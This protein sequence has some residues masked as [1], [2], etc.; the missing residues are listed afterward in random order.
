MTWK[1]TLTASCKASFS[2]VPRLYDTAMSRAVQPILQY[3]FA[4]HEVCNLFYAELL[5]MLP[6]FGSLFLGTYVVVCMYV[7]RYILEIKHKNH[8]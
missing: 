5:L 7:C 3:G 2:H 8:F 1:L 6:M 4:G